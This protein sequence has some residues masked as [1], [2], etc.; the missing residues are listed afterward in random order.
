VNAVS[1]ISTGAVRIH[2]GQRYG[3]RSPLY[4]WLLTS[5]GLDTAAAHSRS[6]GGLDVT[7]GPPHRQAPLPLAGDFT[8]EAEPALTEQQQR[9]S[10]VLPA[11]DPTAAPRLLDS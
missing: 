5:R 2:P 6:H 7:A 10:V 1:V 9:R 11:H 8:Y 3:S 4:W